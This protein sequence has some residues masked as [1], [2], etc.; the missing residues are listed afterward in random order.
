MTSSADARVRELELAL[1]ELAAHHVTARRKLR[2]AAEVVA[3]SQE[4]QEQ[5]GQAQS[6][7]ESAEGQLA[8]A[9][10]ANLALRERATTLEH[11][12]R[13]ARRQEEAIEAELSD[14]R[15]AVAD[16]KVAL[17][18]AEERAAAER[19]R[20][21]AA[22]ASAAEAREAAEREATE[23]LQAARR[24]VE[25]V[26]EAARL[27]VE[28]VREAAR[29]EVEEARAAARREVEEI[30][31]AAGRE[32][33]EARA[34][35]HAEAEA[36]TSE[37]SVR[38]AGDGVPADGNELERLRVELAGLQWELGE[39]ASERGRIE[40]RLHQA[41]QKLA[42]QES[43]AHALIKRAEVAENEAEVLRV[44]GH[45]KHAELLEARN[46]ILA[47][48]KQLTSGASPPSAIAVAPLPETP[49]E[50][51]SSAPTE[52]QINE[53][54]ARLERAQ[55]ETAAVKLEVNGRPPSG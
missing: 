49:P 48:D 9:R 42:E 10:A 47:L 28:E 12:L 44:R 33:D 46:R 27:E 17:G 3:A 35:A 52:E 55:K 38:A 29:L 22:T 50:L 51:A 20:A 18:S 6:E 1:S 36:Q 30:R 4:A 13:D 24:E 43:A 45:E 25:E 23:A 2:E 19:H 14:L 11:E 41:E 53:F 26:R 5:L 16:L 21:D 8:D 7:S 31:Q 32:L 54:A 40:T 15:P 39:T 34:R 37:A